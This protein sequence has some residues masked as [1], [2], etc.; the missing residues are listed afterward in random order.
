[1]PGIKY[2]FRDFLLKWANECDSCALRRL[3][4]ATD[5]TFDD[6]LKHAGLKFKKGTHKVGARKGSEPYWPVKFPEL[7]QSN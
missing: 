4:D 3:A 6:V 1:M 5:S 7:Y 2:E